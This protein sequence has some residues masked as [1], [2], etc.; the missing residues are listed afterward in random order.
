MK[1]CA[2]ALV[3]SFVSIAAHAEM[4][5]ASFSKPE[6]VS[7]QSAP[8]AVSSSPLRQGVRMAFLKPVLKMKMKATV[9]GFG[10]FT[11]TEKLDSANGVSV[12]YAYLPIQSA[13]FTT[14]LA[15]INIKENGD[16][17]VSM[18]R[19][20]GNL[21][22]AVNPMM[23]FKGG[24]NLTTLNKSEFRK[25]FKPGVGFQASAGFQLNRNLG[26]DVGYVTMNQQSK[27]IDGVSM[28]L[29]ESGPEV[30]LTGTF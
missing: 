5:E 14:N 1:A 27:T 20:D 15:L 23:N 24:L 17:S 3:V 25:D 26:V 11:D 8:K 18:I 4:P 12:G 29:E 30:S 6:G 28:S 16:D 7:T 19:A 10:S 13:G 9:E 21:A 2:I 22:F